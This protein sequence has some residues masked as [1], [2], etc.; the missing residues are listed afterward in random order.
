[1]YR[2]GCT[3]TVPIMSVQCTEVVHL[4]VLKWSYRSG[5]HDEP[6]W[7]CTELVL[8]QQ[9]LPERRYG[10]KIFAGTSFVQPHSG[11]TIPLTVTYSQQTVHKVTRLSN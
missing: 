10:S 2:G 4:Y 8:P 11:I 9:Y 5:P 1:M 3:E 7:S 6:K